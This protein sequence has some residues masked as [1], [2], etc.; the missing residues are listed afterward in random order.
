MK[1]DL[2]AY[3]LNT[4]NLD[5]Q[6]E[7]IQRGYIYHEYGKTEHEARKKLLKMC[8]DLSI[9]TDWHD[10]PL[11]YISLRIT[12]QPEFDKY[13]INGALKTLSEIKYDNDVKDNRDKLTNLLKDNPGAYAYIRKGG[14]YYCSN[15]NGY[16]EF[17]ENAGVYTIKQ[18][19][20]E[21]LGMSLRDYM[22]P[23]LI[24]IAIHNKIIDDKIAILTSKKLNQH[25]LK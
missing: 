22:R 1:P 12:R 3:G 15:F 21:C 25:P 5:N 6:N 13:L 17:T 23:E 10:E 19:V 18:A 8:F 16:S 14:Y 24:D 20:S 2:K 9:D 11:T 7:S 4:R